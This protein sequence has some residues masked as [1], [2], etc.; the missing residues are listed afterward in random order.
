[1]PDPTYGYLCELRWHRNFTPPP[2]GKPRVL[3][4]CYN[5]NRNPE[6][7]PEDMKT[8]LRAHYPEYT[9]NFTTISPPAR[10]RET[11]AKGRLRQRNAI[12]RGLKQGGPLFGLGLA[13]KAIEARPDYFA[14]AE[15]NEEAR[16]YTE[17]HDRAQQERWQAFLAWYRTQASPKAAAPWWNSMTVGGQ[18]V[19]PVPTAEPRDPEAEALAILHR[20]PDLCRQISLLYHQWDAERRKK[21]VRGQPVINPKLGEL[22]QAMQELIDPVAQHLFLPGFYKAVRLAEILA[23]EDLQAVTAALPFTT[24]KSIHSEP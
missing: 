18:A 12:R 13:R 7:L 20:Q 22:L 8:A 17:A 9:L 5:I 2:E 15:Q 6:R 3:M 14:G 4:A 21:W 1:M 10:R 24:H 23:Q 16:Q 19:T 11:H